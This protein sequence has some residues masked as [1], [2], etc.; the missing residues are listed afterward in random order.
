[1]KADWREPRPNPRRHRR[2]YS[3]RMLWVLVT[4][5]CLL[6]GFVGRDAYEARI[7]QR[8][9]AQV[10]E[11]GATVTY[12]YEVDE[13]VTT[14]HDGWSLTTRWFSEPPWLDQQVGMP[15]YSRVARIRLNHYGTEIDHT[16]VLLK[17]Q[18]LRELFIT[19][20][21][22]P[23]DAFQRLAQMPALRAITFEYTIVSTSQLRALAGSTSIESI[24]FSPGL[25]SDALLAELWRFPCLKEVRVGGRDVTGRGVEAL[26]KCKTLEEIH[27]YPISELTIDNLKSLT[28]LPHL[29]RFSS[30]N[31]KISV[32]AYPVFAQMP[33][34]E[35]LNIYEGAYSLMSTP[36]GPNYESIED[37]KVAYESG[38][39]IPFRTFDDV[40]VDVRELRKEILETKQE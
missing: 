34:L 37:L 26:A 24:C 39:E 4:G 8:V 22:L 11:D 17:L 3:M 30:C 5:L 16:P 27:L 35:S 18:Q 29:K 36:L 31:N 6:L 20:R 12:D 2:T 33:A 25:G 14:E 40:F 7:E 1:M 21:T 23:D 32:R 15:V 9:V 28:A 10:E 19:N 38:K 13:E